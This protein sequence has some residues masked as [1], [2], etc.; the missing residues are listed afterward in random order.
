MATLKEIATARINELGLEKKAER[1]KVLLFS[2][3]LEESSAAGNFYL[4]TDLAVAVFIEV[5]NNV[6]KIKSDYKTWTGEWSSQ[7]VDE[8]DLVLQY[9]LQGFLSDWADIKARIVEVINK[10]D[11][12]K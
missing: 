4:N 12:V 5:H 2:E 1:I 10:A 8:Y 7:G 11:T 6:V 3:G 9:S